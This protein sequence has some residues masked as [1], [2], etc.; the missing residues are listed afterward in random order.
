MNPL[1]ILSEQDYNDDEIVR[2]CLLSSLMGLFIFLLETRKISATS[3]FTA[4]LH[5]TNLHESRELYFPSTTFWHKEGSDVRFTH[6]EATVKSI[7]LVE[8][9]ITAVS[10]L[11]NNQNVEVPI[12]SSYS[13]AG[14]I[15]TSKIIATNSAKVPSTL[16]ALPMATVHV[17]PISCVNKQNIAGHL[18]ATI[19]HKTETVLLHTNKMLYQ[20]H[21]FKMVRFF[22]LVL[23]VSIFMLFELSIKRINFVLCEIWNDYH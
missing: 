11:V 12:D 5:T 1:S 3:F 15:G 9:L 4:G 19:G 21:N 18:R 10:K 20:F 8:G 23:V 7:C 16:M 6:Q 13:F 14:S 22:F 2:Q 17:I